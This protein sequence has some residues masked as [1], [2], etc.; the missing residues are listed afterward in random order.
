MFTNQLPQ[1]PNFGRQGIPA[2]KPDLTNPLPDLY[3]EGP[4][5]PQGW[6][7]TF[8]LT[9]LKG[10]SGG[11]G[12]GTGWWAGLANLYWWCDRERGVLGM[13][14]S[15]ILPFAGM[16]FSFSVAGAVAIG[17]VRMSLVLRPAHCGFLMRKMAF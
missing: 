6:G 3:P 7:L 9:D 12:K 15:Q 14:A 13:V 4:D 1:M 10:G 17:R 16:L 5:T 2:A 11:R 8:M